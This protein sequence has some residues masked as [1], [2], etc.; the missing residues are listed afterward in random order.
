MA[1]KKILMYILFVCF[2]CIPTFVFAADDDEGKVY[3]QVQDV[4]IDENR[5]QIVGD[6]FN[7]TNAVVSSIRDVSIYISDANG[8]KIAYRFKT[9]EELQRIKLFPGEKKGIPF[10]FELSVKGLERFDFS[11]WSDKINFKYTPSVFGFLYKGFEQLKTG[12][13]GI[14]KVKG[15][16]YNFSNYDFANDGQIV[17]YLVDGDGKRSIE[18]V[19]F[20]RLTVES[21]SR[22]TYTASLKLL[23]TTKYE[24]IDTEIVFSRL[25]SY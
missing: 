7:T 24:I 22:L 12:T 23:P 25:K 6:F 15:Q 13:S 1:S 2:L 19:N 4:K 10:T 11:T 3:F 16:F 17:F 21:N 20:D 9:T 5:V 14:T 8:E 18:R